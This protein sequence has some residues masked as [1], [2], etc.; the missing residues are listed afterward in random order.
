VSGRV[1]NDVIALPGFEKAARC[2]YGYALRL[3][4][5]QGVEKKGVFKRLGIFTARLPHLLQ[6]ALRE[7]IRVGKQPAYQG[8]FSVIDMTDYHDIHV[9]PSHLHV[10]FPS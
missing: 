8:A 3:L 5:F 7:G 2:I 9:F 1:Y 4:V 10:P 6:P